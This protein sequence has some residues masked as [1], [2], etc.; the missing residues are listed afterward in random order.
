MGLTLL[1]A[2][3]GEPLYLNEALAHL[4]VEH[5]EDDGLITAL[6]TTAPTEPSP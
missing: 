6:I 2:P 3:P 1:T 4:R 5:H